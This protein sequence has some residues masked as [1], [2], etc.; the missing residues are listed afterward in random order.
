MR[1]WLMVIHGYSGRTPLPSHSGITDRPPM[2]YSCLSGCYIWFLYLY[3]SLWLS[4]RQLSQIMYVYWFYY[5]SSNMGYVFG[6]V[7]GFWS[8]VGKQP[9]R[10]WYGLLVQHL[11]GLNQLGDYF[12]VL[13][14]ITFLA[15]SLDHSPLYSPYRGGYPSCCCFSLCI[16]LC[17]SCVLFNFHLETYLVDYVKCYASHV[18]QFAYVNGRCEWYPIIQFV[19]CKKDGSG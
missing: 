3:I 12:D 19:C 13:A 11:R 18:Y 6:L 2:D 4:I 9:G 1:M 17:E 16:S 14:V 10:S 8:A 5:S 15:H 7:H